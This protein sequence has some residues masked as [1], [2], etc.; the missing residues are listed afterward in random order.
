MGLTWD[1]VL[2]AFELIDTMEELQA[3]LEDIEGFLRALASA[4]GPAAKRLAIARLRPK[5]E[6]QAAKMSLTWED[7]LPVLEKIDTIGELQKALD[8]PEG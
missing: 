5:L 7:L 4:A 6:V 2:P 8:D 3:A 1:D